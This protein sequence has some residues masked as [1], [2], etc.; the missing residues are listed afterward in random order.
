MQQIRKFVLNK[1][2]L[3]EVKESE[4]NVFR[5]ATTD[6]TGVPQVKLQM[7]QVGISEKINFH[8]HAS[9]VLYSYFLKSYLIKIKL[10]EK[11]SKLEERVKRE[12]AAS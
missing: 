10:E 1:S 5:I 7:D 12:R 4:G 3:M 2:S 9:K 8:K 6:V 11:V